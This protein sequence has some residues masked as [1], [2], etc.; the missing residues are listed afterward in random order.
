MILSSLE[1][2]TLMR[3]EIAEGLLTERALGQLPE[4][5]LQELEEHLSCCPHCTRRDREIR[6]ALEQFGQW[7]EPEPPARMVE[8]TIRAL[9]AE[10][11]RES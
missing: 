10:R 1:K 2:E 7:D 5:K 11:D 4:S 6:E 8:S 9:R 3:C